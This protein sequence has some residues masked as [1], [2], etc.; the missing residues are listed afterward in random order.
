MLNLFSSENKTFPEVDRLVHIGACE[1]QP[2]PP[3]SFID[4]GFFLAALPL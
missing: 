4:K 1:F 2:F 3:V